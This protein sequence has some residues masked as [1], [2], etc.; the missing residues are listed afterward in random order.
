MET[1]SLINQ[2]ISSEDNLIQCVDDLDKAIN[3]IFSLIKDSVLLFMQGSYSTAAFISIT[4]CEEVAKA[5]F[6]VYSDGMHPTTRKN[7]FRDH[8]TK[9]RLASF[10][11]VAIG[12]RLKEAIGN[13][14]LKRI[15]NMANYGG[16]LLLRES[17]LYFQRENGVLITPTQ[18][19]NKTLSKSLVLYAIEVFDD[20]LVGYS[21]HS[22]TIAESTSALFEKVANDK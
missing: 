17:A 11:T 14:E 20:A 5:H 8:K 10:P 4:V 2:L 13:E 19:I 12:E 22:I 21:H 1:Y 18:K 3:Y 7:F 9:H 15:M 6:G 16:F